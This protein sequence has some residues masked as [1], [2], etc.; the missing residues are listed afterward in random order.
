MRGQCSGLFFSLLILLESPGDFCSPNS[1]PPV[2]AIHCP[3]GVSIDAALYFKTVAGARSPASVS[4]TIASLTAGERRAELQS[5]LAGLLRLDESQSQASD[6]SDAQLVNLASLYYCLT[7]TLQ[8][9]ADTT[10]LSPAQLRDLVELEVISA[11][12][13]LSDT[14]RAFL[15]WIF[16]SLSDQQL[17][18]LACG[19][20]FSVPSGL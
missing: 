11:V 8:T 7:E 10:R 12:S 15:P 9:A 4:S 16:G 19:A 3:V 13:G 5:E 6:L 20:Q 1:S 14:A 2:P 18:L 17:V